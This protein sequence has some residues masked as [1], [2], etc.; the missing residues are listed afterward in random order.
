MAPHHQL[1]PILDF[2]LCAALLLMPAFVDAADVTL[3]WDK[4][5]DTRVAGYNVY[6]GQKGT[7]FLAAPIGTVKP[8]EPPCCRIFNLVEGQT[9][10]FVTTS[11]DQEDN[12][13]PFSEILYYK[14][15][16]GG[17]QK[18]GSTEGDENIDKEK[19]PEFFLPEPEP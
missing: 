9:Y 13:S 8:A 4:P 17:P 1:H 16:V 6:C 2:I 19:C 3:A 18:K 7:D 14:V 15:P 12:E 10:G 5:A 11:I